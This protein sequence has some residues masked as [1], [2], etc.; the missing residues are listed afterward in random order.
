MAITLLAPLK[1]KYM[2]ESPTYAPISTTT[3]TLNVQRL[4]NSTIEDFNYGIVHVSELN[5]IFRPTITGFVI[6]PAI[7]LTPDF[8]AIDDLIDVRDLDIVHVYSTINT[9]D[10][11]D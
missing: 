11:V 9:F 3:F 5:I 8:R 7:Y 1:A 10:R 2:A 6:T 4:V